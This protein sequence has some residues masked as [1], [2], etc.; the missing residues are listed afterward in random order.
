M[1]L[2]TGHMGK[3]SAL[4][5]QGGGV[6]AVEGVFG[7]G[8]AHALILQ[9]GFGFT[10]SRGKLSRFMRKVVLFIFLVCAFS[11]V[12][13]PQARAD[14]PIDQAAEKSLTDKVDNLFAQWDKAD[15]PGCALGVIRNGQF[16]YKRGYGMANLEYNIPI[17]PT[18]IFWIA[19]TSKQFT[20]MS[21]ALL[22][23]QGKLSLDDDIRKYLPEMPQY[24]SPVTI[25][26]L[27]HHTS[28]IRDYLAL[29]FFAGIPTEDV[30]SD[31]DMFHLMARQTDEDVLAFIARQKDLNFAPGSEHLY[32][33]SGYL[34]LAQIVKRVSG[35]SLRQFAEEN[36]FKPLG[37]ANSHF[38]DDLRLIVKNRA[39][40]YSPIEGGGFSTVVTNFDR[41]GSAGVMTSVEDLLLWDRNFYENRL[42]GG[43]DLI[44]EMVTPG[45][46]AN[47]QKIEYAFG[48]RS[49]QYGG[50]RVI[51]HGGDFFGFKAQL[52]RFP[53]QR[54]S[55]ICLCNSRNIDANLLSYR[56]AT[57]YLADQLKQPANSLSTV[58]S[59]NPV[60]LSAEELATKTGIYWNPV[61]ED[62]WILSV[63]EGKLVDLGGAVLSP[64]SNERFK[65]VGQRR[66]LIFETAHQGG[67]P[68]R[69]R[70]ID[71]GGQPVIYQAVPAM[72]PTSAQLNEY[73]G[74]YYSEE[75]NVT[76]TLFVEGGKL[77]LRRRRSKNMPLDPTFTDAF[78]RD[79]LGLLRFTRNGQNRVSGFLLTAGRVRRLRF[80]RRK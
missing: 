18:S 77:T 54:F 47:G 24:Q 59:P 36:I 8:R 14:G 10:M 46:L 21:I 56:I 79:D 45:V 30:H 2:C 49:S 65:V 4:R 70:Q 66:Q 11:P 60:T 44:N 37:M 67:R 48:L 19:S 73:A 13:F 20:A 12:A 35:K 39:V 69:L 15:S 40:G 63:K 26:H 64:L 75:L 16:V 28:G 41:V 1:T 5:S 25:R 80:E 50:L 43:I 33:N 31:E 34:L 55:V 62:M 72:T 57:I 76:Y 74:N 17:S 9:A 52:L 53:E 51:T 22:A 38:Q 7:N 71:E 61:N 78:M 29:M 23:R 27:I 32:S 42:N 3:T 58:A 6:D 68:L